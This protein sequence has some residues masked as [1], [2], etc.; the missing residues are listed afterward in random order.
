MRGV[1][2][3]SRPQNAKL[4]KKEGRNNIAQLEVLLGG[5]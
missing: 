1:R 3:A 5:P 2:R 4:F